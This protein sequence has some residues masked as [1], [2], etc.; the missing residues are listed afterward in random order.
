[1]MVCSLPIQEAHTSSQQG[2]TRHHGQPLLF[3]FNCKHGKPLENS[4]G[5]YPEHQCL[6]VSKGSKVEYFLEVLMAQSS[7]V[8]HEKYSRMLQVTWNAPD[9]RKMGKKFDYYNDSIA[10]WQA[11]GATAGGYLSEPATQAALRTFHFA[12]KM[13]FKGLLTD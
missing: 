13:S 7:S 2:R 1:M 12:G 11:I 6:E 5:N 10:V 4:C 3:E 8:D 9:L